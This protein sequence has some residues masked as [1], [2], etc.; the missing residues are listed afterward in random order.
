MAHMNTV[1]TQASRSKGSKRLKKENIPF[2]AHFKNPAFFVP[3]TDF[4]AQF[5]HLLDVDIN[6]RKTVS[7]AI[8]ALDKCLTLFKRFIAERGISERGTA[9]RIGLSEEEARGSI[10]LLSA[11]LKRLKDCVVQNFR[12]AEILFGL[13]RADVGFMFGIMEQWYGRFSER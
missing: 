1:N 4:T 8:T 5:K 7:R 9:Y 6:D 12:Q 10:A 3:F 11:K 13:C 2:P